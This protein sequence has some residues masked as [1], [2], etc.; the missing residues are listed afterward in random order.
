S[1]RV[2]GVAELH[3]D[4][5]SPR[6]YG[7][8]RG[9]GEDPTAREHGAGPRGER[10]TGA[11]VGPVA[12][13]RPPPGLQAGASP[14]PLSGRARTTKGP[15]RSAPGPCSLVAGAGP[16]DG[17]LEADL[18]GAHGVV[19]VHAAAGRDAAPAAALLVAGGVAP[20][21]ALEGQA[22]LAV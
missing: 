7:R 13:R 8:G 11:A 17:L 5:L 10:A 21:G 4:V 1:D 3:R 12:G 20:L 18:V 15:R 16:R 2:A 9:G 14:A 22:D 19:G 6:A